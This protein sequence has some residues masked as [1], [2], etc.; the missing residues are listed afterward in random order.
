[1]KEILFYLLFL[2]STKSMLAQNG[3]IACRGAVNVSIDSSDRNH[4]LSD[5]SK[6][7]LELVFEQDFNDKISIFLD[8][9]CIITDTFKTIRNLGLCLNKNSIDYSKFKE[10]PKISI[11]LNSKNNCISF[12]PR[13]NKRIAYI[14]CI[15]GGWSVE[16]SND[17]RDYR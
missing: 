14:N 11:V 4:F 15:K 17:L 9:K 6:R 8:D 13:P 2:I 16:L 5:S 7:E 10:I 1:M 12:Y 3:Q